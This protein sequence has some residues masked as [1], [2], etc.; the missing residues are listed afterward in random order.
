MA[1]S[2][3][4]RL[5]SGMGKMGMDTAAGDT[6]GRPTHLDVGRAMDTCTAVGDHAG[7][8][9]I[10]GQQRTDGRHAGRHVFDDLIQR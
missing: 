2:G 10:H 5:G 3:V 7:A 4:Q 6:P 8:A 1:G 9:A